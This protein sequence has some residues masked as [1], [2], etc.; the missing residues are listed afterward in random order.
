MG[1]EFL[2]MQNYRYWQKVYYHGVVNCV[3]Q[4]KFLDLLNWA[5]LH[6]DGMGRVVTFDERLSDITRR[7]Q[8]PLIK[9]NARNL[10]NE[11]KVKGYQ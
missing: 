2:K 7:H 4:S 5:D 3:Y 10:I 9:L 6:V 8:E 1:G 11:L